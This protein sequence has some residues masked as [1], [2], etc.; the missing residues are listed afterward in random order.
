MRIWI[1]ALAAGVA[2]IAACG[3][4]YG[5]GGG[6][7]T[8]SDTVRVNSNNFSPVQVTPDTTGTVVWVWNS[9]G[10][11]HN[12][13]FEDAITG[14]GNKTSGTFSHTFSADGSYRYRCTNHSTNFTS[15]MAGV[16]VVGAPADTVDPPDPY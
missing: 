13:T 3:D 4:D 12:V 9:G 8:G 10:T 7:S 1:A 14:S 5:G 16:V 15:G 2:L 6:T 11:A